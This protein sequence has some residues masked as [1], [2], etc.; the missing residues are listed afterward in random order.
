V[1]LFHLAGKGDVSARVVASTMSAGYGLRPANWQAC[2]PPSVRQVL[3]LISTE[4]N[5][6]LALAGPTPD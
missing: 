5:A 3:A 1:S 4:A 6:D 2:R